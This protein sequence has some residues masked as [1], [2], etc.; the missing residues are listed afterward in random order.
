MG[1]SGRA[2]EPPEYKN[3]PQADRADARRVG[4]EA[5][6]RPVGTGRELPR[7]TFSKCPPGLWAP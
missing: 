1:M 4:R 2:M 6:L 3:L 5:P 7:E